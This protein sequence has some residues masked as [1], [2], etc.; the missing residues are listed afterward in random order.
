MCDERIE[1]LEGCAVR[2]V[3]LMSCSQPYLLLCPFSHL[4]CD[5]HELV[6]EVVDDLLE[7]VD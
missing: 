5:A 3:I 1:S 4:L 6:L 2:Y 7:L